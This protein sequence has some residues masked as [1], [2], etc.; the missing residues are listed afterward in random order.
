MATPS[1]TEA[2]DN[3][4]VTT[5]IEMKKE[6][7]DNIFSGTPF[8]EYLTKNGR[9]GTQVGGRK[10]EY[11]LE[12]G[13]NSTVTAVGRGTE[14]PPQDEELFT[15]AMYEWRYIA[16]AILRYGVDDQKNAGKAQIINLLTAKIENLKRSLIDFMENILFQNQTGDNPNG[17]VDLIAIDPTTG[18]IGGIDRATYP[19]W[20]NKTMQATGPFSSNGISD[21]RKLFYTIMDGRPSDKPDGILTDQNTFEAYEQE[22]LDFAQQVLGASKVDLS[23]ETLYFKGVPMFYSPSAPQ[24]TMYMMNSKY[25]KWVKDPRMDFEPTEWKPITNQIN[26]RVLH[27]IE[28][29]NLVMSRAKCQG[30]L[31]TIT[32]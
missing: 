28:A 9:I 22:A 26:D 15:A 18:V 17:I 3:L 29:G 23:F 30:V 5:L 20:R 13:K 6:L 24:G 4:Y 32:Y 19:W 11:S 25:F 16:G 1:M 7:T 27:I 10:I 31:H 12:Y 2:L 14:L 21:M 8:W